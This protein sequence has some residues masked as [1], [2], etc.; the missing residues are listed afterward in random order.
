MNEQTVRNLKDSIDI[1]SFIEE[2]FPLNRAG[3]NYK[4]LCPFHI[5]KTPSFVVSSRTQLFKCYGCG[6]GGDVIDFIQK[7]DGM[8]FIDAVKYLADKFQIDID[9]ENEYDTTKLESKKEI[10]DINKVAAYYFY[11]RL[12]SLEG[13]EAK[14]YLLKRNISEEIM[15]KFLVGYAPKDDMYFNKYISTYQDLD[16]DI[17]V[18]ADLMFSNGKSKFI[19]RIMFPI[20]D[21]TSGVKGFGGRILDP[22]DNPKYLNSSATPVFEKSKALYG[23]RHAKDSIRKEKKAIL[24]EGYIDVIMAH[25][26][27]IKNTVASL[28]T[29]LT[30]DNV[31]KLKHWV[32]DVVLAF[33][34]DDAGDKATIRGI[35]LVI[36]S[37]I[38][39][40]ICVMPKGCDPYDIINKDPSEFKNMVESA[41]DMLTWRI[42][43]GVYKHRNIKDDTQKKL[44]IVLELMPMLARIKSDIK[45]N[46]M[47]KII[48]E[49]LSI[50]ESAIRREV[51]K[52]VINTKAIK[53][54]IEFIPIK[55]EDEILKEIIR[56]IIK[57]P[58]VTSAAADIIGAGY[59][60][61]IFNIFKLVYSNKGDLHGILGT[62]NESVKK[63][64]IEITFEEP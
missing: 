14:D 8:G 59:D 2:R 6:E 62:S 64:L 24:L 33:D 63:S 56:I 58:G 38:H 53:S 30:E 37:D 27:G 5:E 36:A 43:Y 31:Y 40:D 41:E 34:S 11:E 60:S 57:D 48:A 28:G 13:K 47:I 45:L 55:K 44:K 54:D 51:R 16:K 9:L 50:R 15:E 39:G 52:K 17:F 29:A 35:D 7:M 23:L 12:H 21:E 19:N 20:I 10:L 49:R 4:A 1:V 22:E 61:E 42:N 46:E 32:D 18:A 3:V 26:A 25:Q